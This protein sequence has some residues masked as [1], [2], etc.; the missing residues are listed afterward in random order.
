MGR[1]T[2]VLPVVRRDKELVGEKVTASPPPKVMELVA[3]VVLSFAVKVFP[4]AMVRVEPVSGAVNATLLMLVAVATPR[5]G[6]TRVGEVAKTRAPVPVA[7]VEVT[8]S[9]VTWPVTERVPPKVVAFAPE[10]VKVLSK[11]VAPCKVRVPGVVAEPMTF[12]E[13]APEPKVVLLVEE[14]VPVTEVLPP[15]AVVPV[16]ASAFVPIVAPPKAREVPEATPK[17]GVTREGEVAKTAAPV[18]VSSESEV[19]NWRE[20]MEPVAVP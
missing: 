20:V 14:K 18:P 4:S 6:V 10:T 15:S 2:E 19:A 9:R 13:D 5:V 7:P 16:T 12:T 1:V 11:V 8:P 17:E 3:K